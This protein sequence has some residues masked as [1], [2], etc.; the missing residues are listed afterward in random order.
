VRGDANATYAIFIAA[1]ELNPGLPMPGINGL[2]MLDGT[3]EPALPRFH[4][5]WMGR[6][7]RDRIDRR[8][9]IVPR[10]R[11]GERRRRGSAGEDH[12][13]PRASLPDE[14]RQVVRAG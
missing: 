13:R 11:H 4:V 2:L 1:S 6:G 14:E 3:A 8:R 5:L 12:P 10:P 9:P 7:V